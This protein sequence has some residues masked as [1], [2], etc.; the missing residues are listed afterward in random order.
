MLKLFEILP[1]TN[2]RTDILPKPAVDTE[3][4][5]TLEIGELKSEYRKYVRQLGLGENT[6]NTSSNDAFYLWKNVN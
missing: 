6:V 4:A 3:I 1:K 5:K 2:L